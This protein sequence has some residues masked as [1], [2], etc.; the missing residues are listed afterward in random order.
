MSPAAAAL[1]ATTAIQAGASAAMLTLPSVAPLVAADLGV[2]TSLVGSYL[3]LAYVGAATAALVGGA[4]V[5]R[6]GALRLSQLA[7]LACAIGLLLG[8]APQLAVVALSAVIL[9]AGYGPITP[10]SSH[11]LARTASAARMGLTFS[12]KQTGVPAGAALAGLIVPPL[13]LAAGWRVAVAAMALLALVITLAAQPTR[14]TLDADR[15]RDARLLF[16]HFAAALR[17]VAATPA[18]RTMAAVSFVY[19]GLQVCVMG[20]IVAYLAEDVGLDLVTAGVALTV[21]NVAGVAARIGWGSFAD[22]VLSAR[23]TLA[24]L[25]GLMAAS[26]AATALF[27]AAW[28]LAALLTVVAALG[29]T[30]IGWNGV[31]LAETARV[32]PPGQAA[33]A[34]GG[35]L[36]FTYVGVVFCPAVFGMLQRAS[37]SYA[38]CFAAAAV[39]YAVVAA[40]LLLRRP[41]A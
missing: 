35:C 4:A 29:G 22:R 6:I 2:P 17:L 25:G 21:A 27:S 20:F 18:L 14:A 24:L 3:S 23:A 33:L 37:G 19:A 16:G 38:L 13:A 12:I 41:R 28:P 5:P 32:A 8:L 40:A 7:L 31:Y 34:T 26:A 15:R 1:A 9:G 30:A 39:A 10:A 36:F 11:L